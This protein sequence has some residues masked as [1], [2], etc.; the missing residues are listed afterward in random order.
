MLSAKQINSNAQGIETDKDLKGMPVEITK[1]ISSS[2]A[3][4]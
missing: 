1:Q 3:T 4:N 2:S